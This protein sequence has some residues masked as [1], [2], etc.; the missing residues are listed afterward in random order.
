MIKVKRIRFG[1]KRDFL[2]TIGFAP[3]L[4]QQIETIFMKLQSRGGMKSVGMKS[5][6]TRALVIRQPLSF[7]GGR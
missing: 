7:V 1:M 2:H 4:K 5:C 3:P 6:V